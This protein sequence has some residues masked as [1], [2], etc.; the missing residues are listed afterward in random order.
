[1]SSHRLLDPQT[2]VDDEVRQHRPPESAEYRRDDLVRRW[3]AYALH[4]REQATWCGRHRA[5]YDQKLHTTRAQVRDQAANLLRTEP[6]LTA[7]AA[8]MMDQATRHKVTS[9]P[10]LIGFDE[11]SFEYTAARCWQACAWDIDPELPQVQPV[12]T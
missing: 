5:G 9:A 10:P 2:D 11:T 4:S 7:A 8:K 3:L 12:W 6:D 1:M